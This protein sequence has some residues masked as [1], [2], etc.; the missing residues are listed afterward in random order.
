MSGNARSR[1]FESFST[2]ASPQ[3]SLRCFSTMLSPSPQYSWIS[4]RFTD[5]AAVMR[6]TVIRSFNSPR[7]AR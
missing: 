1:S 2:T 3:P 7:N 5:R 6:D 4:S